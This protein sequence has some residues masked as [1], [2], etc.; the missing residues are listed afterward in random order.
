MLG[1]GAKPWPGASLQAENGGKHLI[2]A[3]QGG[4]ARSR[5]KLAATFSHGR[6]RALNIASIMS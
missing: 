5:I 3:Y 2:V 1:E 4:A 6:G